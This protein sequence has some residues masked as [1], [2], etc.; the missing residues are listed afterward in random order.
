MGVHGVATSVMCMASH[1][2]NGVHAMAASGACM[3]SRALDISIHGVSSLMASS[4]MPVSSMGGGIVFHVSARH[5]YGRGT[6]S[7]RQLSFETRLL[8]SHYHS[9]SVVRLI[10]CLFSVNLLVPAHHFLSNS[11]HGSS[12]Y[13]LSDSS[14]IISIPFDASLVGS[15]PANGSHWTPHRSNV[16][17]R[18]PFGF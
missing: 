4:T 18:K 5:E 15:H 14:Y 16:S 1:P 8:A 11:S 17:D 9:Q 2:L 7:T 3:A 6:K 10:D 12:Y 13:Y